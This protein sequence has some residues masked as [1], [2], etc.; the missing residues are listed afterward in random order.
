MHGIGD[1]L[2]K[3]VTELV[4]CWFTWATPLGELSIHQIQEI[5]QERRALAQA[6]YLPDS[7]RSHA[8][9]SWEYRL[10]YHDYPWP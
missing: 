1:A 2:P 6:G 9:D 10:D 8:V 5:V 7:G 4:T 3:V